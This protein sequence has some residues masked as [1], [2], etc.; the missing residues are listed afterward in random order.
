MMLKMAIAGVAVLVV[1][2]APSAAPSEG[3]LWDLLVQSSLKDQMI[4]VGQ[5]PV[6]AGR[7]T[8][9]AGMPVHD[10]DITIRSGA[11]A[12]HMK[13][14]G[15][16]GFEQELA[17]FDG[18]PGRYVMNIKAEHGERTGWD[19]LQ[20]QVSGDVKESEILL[21]QIGTATA[22]RYISAGEGD[23][24][25]DPIGMQL[26]LHY[27]QIYADYLDAVERENAEAEAEKILDGQRELARQALRTDIEENNPGAGTY[28]GWAYD[29]FVDNLD[30][31]VKEIIVGQLNHTTTTF[32]QAGELMDAVLENGGTYQ[33][34][35][36]AYLNRLSMSQEMMNRL[37][38]GQ[39]PTEP[40]NST[41]AAGAAVPGEDGG[42]AG[43]AGR[44]AGKPPAA[45]TGANGTSAGG[46]GANGTSAGGT[47]TN[48]AGI[49]VEASGNSVFIDIGGVITEFAVNGTQL[50]RVTNS[51][52]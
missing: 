44:A 9:H 46:T 47:G 35:R 30:R 19:T 2:L 52:G 10:A 18:L 20:F 11:L 5:S 43:A 12:F 50:V 37:A 6:V 8:D 42:G 14:D 27:R 3:V 23:F 48:G 16:G 32:R 1:A 34:A 13:T 36:E 40:A 4:T 24:A 38:A 17:G 29:R 21:R 25:D 39:S 7:V 26:Y 33:E 41:D 22:Q 51:T 31:S 15:T 49:T 45:A 28:G